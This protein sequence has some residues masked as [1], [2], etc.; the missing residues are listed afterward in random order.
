[1]KVVV[2]LEHRF[3]RTPDGIVWTHTQFPYSFWQRYLE[4]FDHVRVVARV[5]D[6]LSVPSDW[7]ESN[8]DS[9]SIAAIPYYC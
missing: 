4:V 1:M 5:Q 9:I 3:N 7:K 6:V 8:G 2:A